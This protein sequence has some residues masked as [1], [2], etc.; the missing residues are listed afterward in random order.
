MALV[1]EK[2]ILSVSHESLEKD[3]GHNTI[4]ECFLIILIKLRLRKKQRTN[5]SFNSFFRTQGI[6]FSY[7][8]ITLDFYN[9]FS[10]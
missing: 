7:S 10:K 4:H 2:K 1:S 9:I 3:I 8:I 6:S 5:Q